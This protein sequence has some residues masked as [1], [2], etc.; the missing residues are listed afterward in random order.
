MSATLFDLIKREQVDALRRLLA[1]N[2]QAS[3]ARDAA[4]GLGAITFALYH[5]SYGA[6]RLLAAARQDL[7]WAEACGLGELAR[8]ELLLEQHP[9]LLHSHTADG[10]TAL[11]LCCFF[12]R[13]PL[14][15]MLVARG[16]SVDALASGQ[17]L[18]RPLHSAVAGRDLATVEALLAAKPDVNARQSRGFVALHAAALNGDVAIVR[19]LLAAGADPQARADDGKSAQDFARERAH[20]Q[21]EQLLAP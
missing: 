19:A 16:A 8:L 9:T 2:P 18:L 13:A 17:S 10:F 21:V 1:A 12:G 5:R 20:A 14:V 6:A 4:T 7:D 3:T 11:H 15:T